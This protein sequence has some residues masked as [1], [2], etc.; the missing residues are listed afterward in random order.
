MNSSNISVNVYDMTYTDC[1]IVP[2]IMFNSIFR[3]NIDT[4]AQ[5]LLRLAYTIE[6]SD[7]KGL[8]SGVINESFYTNQN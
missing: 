3:N 1:Y 8:I 6:L 7:Q 5:D 4:E 2:M